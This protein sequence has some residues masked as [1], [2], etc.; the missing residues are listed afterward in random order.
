MA[1]RE[2]A[3]GIVKRLSCV[4]WRV[5]EWSRASE[6]ERGREREKERG[7]VGCW[8]QMEGQ[9]RSALQ[10]LLARFSLGLHTHLYSDLFPCAER[11]ADVPSFELISMYTTMQ[12]ERRDWRRRTLAVS[13]ERKP[14][15][16]VGRWKRGVPAMRPELAVI[17]EMGPGHCSGA[18]FP[19]WPSPMDVVDGDEWSCSCLY[20]PLT[21]A[22]FRG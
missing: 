7:S 3:A 10:Q 15:K 5:C 18:S 14:C 8:L 12:I 2:A 21:D 13:S 9:R 4:C 20:A 17:E 19:L 1:G 22:Y 16:L 11:E 6:G